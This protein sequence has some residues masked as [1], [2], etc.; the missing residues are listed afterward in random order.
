MSQEQL[1]DRVGLT[2][3]QV[4]KY[5]R[6]ANRI[7]AGRLFRI[8]CALD[9]RVSYF[10]DDLPEDM[11]SDCQALLGD[12]AD[13]MMTR[14]ET[15]ELVAA[16]YRIKDVGMRQ[17]VKEII[18]AVAGPVPGARKRGRPPGS[19]SKVGPPSPVEA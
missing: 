6:G 12:D 3:Q 15:L 2:F 4:Q 14:R 1:G 11:P 19:K 13:D 10:F 9:V 17:R 5:E 8:A 16:F 18:R 7:S